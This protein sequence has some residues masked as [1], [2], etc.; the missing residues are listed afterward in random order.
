M[1]RLSIIQSLDSERSQYLKDY[2]SNKFS[3]VREIAE[4]VVNQNPLFGFHSYSI[5][6]DGEK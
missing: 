5:W 3:F 6:E 4:R 1:D 2:G